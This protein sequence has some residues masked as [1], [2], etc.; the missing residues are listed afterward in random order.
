MKRPSPFPTP[1][2]DWQ[3]YGR[4][5]LP[6]RPYLSSSDGKGVQTGC[7]AGQALTG[8]VEPPAAPAQGAVRWS[9][10]SH[11]QPIGLGVTGQHV[12]SWVRLTFGAP[13]GIAKAIPLPSPGPGVNPNDQYRR[14]NQPQ[15][16][17]PP[18]D[19]LPD[20]RPDPR[21]LRGVTISQGNP[22]PQPNPE[23][24]QRRP[25][26]QGEKENKVISRSKAISIAIFRAL[27]TISESAEL[28]N[29]VYEA[30]PEDVRKRWEK[31]RDP[32]GL[33]DSAGQYGID[34]ADWKLQALWHNWHRVDT[35]AA[36]ENIAKNL[37]EDKLYGSVYKHL[38]GNLGMV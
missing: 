6:Q 38:P 2:N 1:M 31:G 22:R 25:P 26:G 21:K 35:V 14:G 5:G 29:A 15:P 3:F 20:P 33:L 34:G 11:N 7:L 17:E 28:V 30:L 23:P 27:D 4:C 16:I 36:V 32:R 12:E 9:V 37:G 10:W 13:T 19:P 18:G 24:H 8:N